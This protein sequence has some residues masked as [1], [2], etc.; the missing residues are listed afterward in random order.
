[1]SILKRETSCIYVP[2]QIFSE[3]MGGKNC[4]WCFFSFMQ[5]FVCLFY[6]AFCFC[7]SKAALRWFKL[8]HGTRH[9]FRLLFELLYASAYI[10]MYMYQH[11]Y[12]YIYMYQYN[13]RNNLANI[14]Y[15]IGR[16]VFEVMEH[17]LPSRFLIVS[18][19]QATG[20]HASP[21]FL[22]LCAV[23]SVSPRREQ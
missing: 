12:I 10:Y 13:S 9:Y 23:L 11:T 20:F 15:K 7:F 19:F 8:F 3:W 2:H 6:F 4:V 21:R 18:W 5:F 14:S 22:L 16:G 17:L 1:M